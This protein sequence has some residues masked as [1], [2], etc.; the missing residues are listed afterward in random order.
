MK[1]AIWTSMSALTAFW[2]AT[3][4]YQVR[5]HCRLRSRALSN[6]HPPKAVKADRTPPGAGIWKRFRAV[7]ATTESRVVASSCRAA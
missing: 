1:G 5:S 3:V 6:S 7:P 4:P 2:I